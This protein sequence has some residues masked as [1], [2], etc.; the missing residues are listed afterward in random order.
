M[1]KAILG[2]TAAIGLV[3]IAIFATVRQ[4]RKDISIKA[5]KAEYERKAQMIREQFTEEELN[6][7]QK[8]K[9]RS[10]IADN[11]ASIVSQIPLS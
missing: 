4:L 8:K 1:L 5:D 7:V 2:I 3:G 9:E 10:A 6:E 11:L